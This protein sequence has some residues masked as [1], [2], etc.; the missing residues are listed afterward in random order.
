MKMYVNAI[1]LTTLTASL[2]GCGWLM[3]DDGL[4]RDRGNDYRQAKVEAPLAFPKGINSDVID[5]SYVV[6]PISDRTSLGAEF[7]VPRPEPLSTDVN[8]DVVRINTLGSQRWILIDGSPGIVW[9]RLRGFLSLNQLAVQRVDAVNGI[10]E[11]A[12]LE[13]KEENALKERYRLRIE[14]G[15]Q[16]ETSEVYVVQADIRAG[17]DNWPKHSSNDKREQLMIKELAQYLADSAQA[18]SVSMLAQQAIDSSGKVTLEEGTGGQLFIKLGLPFSRAWASLGRALE[19]AGYKIDDL[20]RSE[21]QYYVHYHEQ[22]GNEEE[23]EKG[24]F[25]SLFSFSGEKQNADKG[26]AYIVRMQETDDRGV[27]ITIERQ[28]GE[29]MEVNESD[30]LLKAIK[31]HLS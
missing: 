2:S 5:D 22:S 20:N 30:R 12:W 17:E 4:F 24:F 26:E 3:G 11:T 18:A 9:P 16:R 25:S 8:R 13:P 28:S 31:R 29:S 27:T 1:F 19:K 10:I 15:V 14:Q 7:T 23:E 21:R 6:P